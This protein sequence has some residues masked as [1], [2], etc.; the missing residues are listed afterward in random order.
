[1]SEY[2]VVISDDAQSDIISIT[3]Y[4]RHVLKNISAAKKFKEDTQNALH[5]LRMFPYSHPVWPELRT[6]NNHDVRQFVYRENYCIFYVV[7][8]DLEEV[9]V[10]GVSYTRRNLGEIQFDYEMSR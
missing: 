5:S 3:G 8:D 2:T 10:V 6:F 9:V 4:I 1:M 7:D